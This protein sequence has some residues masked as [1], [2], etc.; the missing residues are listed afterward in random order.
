M[1]NEAYEGTK[2]VS[3]EERLQLPQPASPSLMISACN[4]KRGEHQL[5]VAC[6]SGMTE[7]W[8]LAPVTTIASW[9]WAS[10]RPCC[11]RHAGIHRCLM[12]GSTC[13]SL[14]T[15]TAPEAGTSYQLLLALLPC[16]HEIQSWEKTSLKQTC[17]WARPCG[18]PPIQA[19]L[20]NLKGLYV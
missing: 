5:L 18:S 16:C 20:A 4:C 13:S 6:W 17:S 8:T 2:R 10:L 14:C 12:A 1:R 11:L 3:G 9:G 7:S 15:S 19:C